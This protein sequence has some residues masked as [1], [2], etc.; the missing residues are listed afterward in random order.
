MEA[1]KAAV[2]R[3]SKIKS[4]KYDNKILEENLKTEF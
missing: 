4:Q 1:V 2:V 3:F